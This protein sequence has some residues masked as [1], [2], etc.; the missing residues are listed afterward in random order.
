[1]FTTAVGVSSKRTLASWHVHTPGEIVEHTLGLVNLRETEGAK[2]ENQR[3]SSSP[4]PSIVP[5]TSAPVLPSSVILQVVRGGLTYV[6]EYLLVARAALILA[7]HATQ[8]FVN[9]ARTPR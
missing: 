1:V 4:D 6:Y 7:F 9:L 2:L 8:R 5:S 3:E